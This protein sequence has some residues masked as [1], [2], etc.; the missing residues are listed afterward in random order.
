MVGKALEIVKDDVRLGVGE[1]QHLYEDVVSCRVGVQLH[2]IIMF[3]QTETTQRPR[4][5]IVFG[6]CPPET[7]SQW[8][9]SCCPKGLN[10]FHVSDVFAFLLLHASLIA[11]KQGCVGACLSDGVE[12]GTV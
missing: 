1:L 4:H 10:D 2:L 12:E 5:Q 11:D 7:M 3:P 9:L 6:M 8:I